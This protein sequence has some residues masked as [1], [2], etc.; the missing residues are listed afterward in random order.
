M[1]T[2]KNL[3]Y[4]CNSQK[5]SIYRYSNDINW[6]GFGAYISIESELLPQCEKPIITYKDGFV[7]FSCDTPG[8]TFVP[9][10]EFIYNNEDNPDKINL[11][12]NYIVKV[13]A[14]KEGYRDSEVAVASGTCQSGQHTMFLACAEEG[15]PLFLSDWPPQERHQ[16]A[17]MGQDSALR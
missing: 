12:S 10:V 16:A 5:C 13:Y 15:L 17:D 6:K 9:K 14:T 11:S 7:C 1:G 8:V 4:S 3:R 2:L